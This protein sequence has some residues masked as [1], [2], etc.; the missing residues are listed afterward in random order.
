MF[1][2]VGDPQTLLVNGHGPYNCNASLVPQGMS[3]A[4]QSQCGVPQIFVKPATRYRVRVIAT[5]ALSYLQMALEGHNISVFEV[6]VSRLGGWCR[7]CHSR[8]E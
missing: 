7:S 1:T 8:W 5:G 2:W 6:D 4:D 3:C